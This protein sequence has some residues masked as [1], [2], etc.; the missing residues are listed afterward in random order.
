MD[1][2]D[3][4]KINLIQNEKSNIWTEKNISSSILFSYI[5]SMIWMRP[6]QGGLDSK[7]N[8]VKEREFLNFPSQSFILC[9]TCV[10]CCLYWRIGTDYR[11]LVLH[12]PNKI[13][14]NMRRRRKGLLSAGDLK[15]ARNPGDKWTKKKYEKS[16]WQSFFRR[17]TLPI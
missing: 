1:V 9:F 16:I 6:F 12:P 13:I 8:A 2:S 10:V 5:L 4:I 14:S 11:G 15:M 17:R 7:I 3:R